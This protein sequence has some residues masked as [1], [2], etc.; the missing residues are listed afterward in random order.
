MAIYIYQ[1]PET[2]EQIEV[3]QLMSDLH[4]H[5]GADGLE[6]SRVYTVP[7]ASFDSILTNPYSS[8]EFIKSTREKKMTM[9][10]VW[11]A[12]AELSKQRAD[13]DGTDPVRDKFFVD[14]KKKSDGRVT[15]FKNRK[16]KIETKFVTASFND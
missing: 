3:F 7:N 13:K 14:Y 4:I 5:I 15:H 8:Q 10:E 9:G 6:W 1:H 11:D 2:K 16:K 12:S